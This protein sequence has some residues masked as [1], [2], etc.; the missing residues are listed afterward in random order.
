MK[1]FS[2]FVRELSE[3]RTASG[4]Q[5]F[6]SSSENIHF[7][8]WKSASINQLCT[9]TREK[10]NVSTLT[11]DFSLGQVLRIPLLASGHRPGIYTGIA[12]RAALEGSALL[13]LLSPLR[14]LS[15]TN[16]PTNSLLVGPPS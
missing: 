5:T 2:N 14:L 7:I 10:L 15:P 13:L 4:K 1:R 3:E 9:V 11:R 6:C 12:R 16:P 8:T